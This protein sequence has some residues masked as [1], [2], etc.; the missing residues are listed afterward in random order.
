MDNLK[1]MKRA[2]ELAAK[3]IGRTTPNPLVG[4]VIV[5][6]NGHVVGEGYH[7]KAGTPHAEINAL[8][9]AGNKAKGGTIYVNLE[10]CSHYG[11]TPPCTDALI[12]ASLKKVVVGMEDPNPLVAGRGIKKLL[13]NGL[14]V[15]VGVLEQEAIKLNKVFIKFIT[16]GLPYITYKTA[17]T[18]DGKIATESGDSKWVTG[19]N[20]RALVHQLRDQVNGIM[21]GINTI[22]ADNPKLNT[23]LHEGGRDPIRIIL[24]SKLQIP[25]TANVFNLESNAK[26]I[27]ATTQKA[28]KEKIKLLS[29]ADVEV[30]NLPADKNGQV[31]LLQLLKWLG[32]KEICHILLEGGGNV[33]TSFLKQQFIDELWW[34]IA[35]KILGGSNSLTPV[36]ELEFTKM[37]EA[38][39]INEISSQKIGEDIL[40]TGFL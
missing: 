7:K 30:V 15:E 27:I 36:R 25:S 18:L 16:T 32:E 21:V 11:K 4:A 10:P 23:R 12:K 1:H 9:A 39:K 29:S 2:L 40:I 28:S 34:F 8:Q 35:P 19:P 13:N 31:D 17:T 3:A 6:E 20:A 37:K 22:L 24:D 26:T 14:E 33:A 38:I 5:D